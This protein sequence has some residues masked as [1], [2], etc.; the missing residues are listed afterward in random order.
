MLASLSAFSLAAA[1][2]KPATDFTRQANDA[3]LKSRPFNDKQDFED[4][5][6][7]LV[8]RPDTLTIKNEQG[9]VVWDLEQYTQLTSRP[10]PRRPIP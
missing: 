6:R 9:T 5:R 8:A 1:E 3:V 7:G 2:P 4:A 10:T